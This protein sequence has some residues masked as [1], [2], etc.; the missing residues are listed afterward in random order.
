MIWTPLLDVEPAGA[1]PRDFTYV[2]SFVLTVCAGRGFSPPKGVGENFGPHVWDVLAAAGAT[3]AEWGSIG[4][5]AAERA[6]LK[7]PTDPRIY[8]S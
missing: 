8:L 2:E 3:A 5:R 4:A 7:M 6:R 1:F